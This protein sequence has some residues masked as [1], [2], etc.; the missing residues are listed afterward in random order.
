M[1]SNWSVRLLQHALRRAAQRHPYLL[2]TF[3]CVATTVLTLPLLH[4]VDL[5][6]I[7]LLFVLSVV[8]IATLLGRRP[9]VLA[10]LLAV[11][12][13]DF[14]FVPP[15][16]SFTVE[17]AQYLITFVVMLVVS[18]II[19]HLTD[20]YRREASEAERRAAES[21][22]LHELA[23]S[24][25]GAPTLDDVVERLVALV[26]RYR[27]AEVTLYVADEA[28]PGALQPRPAAGSSAEAAAAA[29]LFAGG[30]L[31]VEMGSA[32]PV[33]AWQLQP[34]V[35]ATRWR[36]VLAVRPADGAP[37]LPDALRAA[38]AAV[39]TTAIERIHFVE[40][41]HATTLDMQ[42]ER[43]RS[44]IL[45]SLSHDLR[46]P[47]TVLYGL[48]DSLARRD[49]LSPDDLAT[50]GLLRDQCRRLNGMVDNLLDLA[51]LRSGKVEL[52]RDWQSLADIV[53]ASVQAMQPW[54]DS[55]RIRMH[56]VAEAPLIE[57][58]PV[59]MERV[60]CN[61][62]ENA[63]K[64]APPD[65]PIEIHVATVD[66]AKVAPHAVRITIRD[67]GPGF[68]ATRADRLFEI[69]ERADSESAIPGVGV[70]LAVCRAIVEAH[71]GRIA[72]TNAPEGGACVSIELPLGE[73]P[74]IGAEDLA[75]GVP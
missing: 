37:A 48:A 9:A 18:L 21:A 62:L 52:R 17:Q 44:A 13:F 61:L 7:V 53:G 68:P 67:A 15:R 33:A 72:A 22:M 8:L 2:T 39:V 26:R 30:V 47:L 36:G 46:T 31:P 29:A 4:V 34:L 12:L 38:L 64:Y 1:S 57:F 23:E 63:T 32:P 19:S 73:P 69:F 3:A 43:L 70:G 27:Q 55:R 45:S 50:A 20:A 42:A 74:D 10:S 75:E 16:F 51:R 40:V 60:F 35:G 6:N 41:A 56:G 66:D 54:L 65:S 14:F 71:G 28:A 59:L 58:D 24:L 25:S 11:A 5:A 49:G